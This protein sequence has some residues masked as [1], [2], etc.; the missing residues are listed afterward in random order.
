MNSDEDEDM[1]GEFVEDL[2]DEEEDDD[3]EALIGEG[4]EK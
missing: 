3:G 2:D 4:M 1:L